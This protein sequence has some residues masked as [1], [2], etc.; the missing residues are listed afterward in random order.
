MNPE[1]LLTHFDRISDAPDA[2]PR[3]RLFI[4]DLAVRGKLVEQ[5]CSDGPASTDTIRTGSE[6][7]VEGTPLYEIPSAWRFRG[8]GGISE[9]ITDGEHATPPRIQ[10]Q[11]VPLVTAK[12]VRDGFMDF[13]KTDWV[14]FETATKAWKRCH[15]TVGDIL[16]VC[17]GATTGRLC[18]VREARDMVLVRSVALIRPSSIIGADYLALA[19]RSPMAQS[20]IWEKV[21]VS[22]QPCLYINRIDSLLI[23]VPPVSEQRRIVAKVSELMGLC[24]QLEAAQHEQESRQDRLTAAALHH[25]NNA[26]NPGAFREHAYFYVNHLPRL[27]TSLV[28]VQ[29][30]RQTILNLAVRGQL[31]PQKP[32]D[33]P[34][35]ELLKRVQAEIAG[36]VSAGEAKEQKRFEAGRSSTVAY[37]IPQTW[38]WVSLGQVAFGFRYGT[39]MKCS[40]ERTGEPVLR[41]PNIDNGRINVEDLKFGPLPKREADALRLELGD[42]LM[43]RSNGSLNLVGRPALV[44]ANAVGY[45][46]A[47][48]LVRVRTSAIHLDAR[49]LLVALRSTH[50]PGPNRTTNTDNRRLEKCECNRAQQSHDPPATSSRAAAHRCQG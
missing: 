11:Q 40:Y 48:Y 3:L 44:E 22:A 1:L 14:S 47:G 2:I 46:Y 5:G 34:A 32:T 7:P 8:L 15:P 24:D 9:Q 27:T 13:S 25:L 23:P 19:L 6:H 30:L 41:I 45:C 20:Q 10:E 4:L 50:V 36:L 12:N 21:K 33:E 49:Y 38:I 31:V 18:V 26:A 39:S 35:S 16:L 43:V 42:I 17:V 28:H 37:D 29:Q